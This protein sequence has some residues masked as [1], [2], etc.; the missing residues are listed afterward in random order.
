[1][2]SR[3]AIESG[4]SLFMVAEADLAPTGSIKTDF[5]GNFWILQRHSMQWIINL[6]DKPIILVVA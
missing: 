1:M 2:K 5:L 3:S 6:P 4:A